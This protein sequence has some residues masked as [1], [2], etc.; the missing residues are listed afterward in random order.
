MTLSARRNCGWNEVAASEWSEETSEND[1]TTPLV[2]A[3]HRYFLPE[4]SFAPV[5]VGTEAIKV[6]VKVS[7]LRSFLYRAKLVVP[8][9]RDV[10][11]FAFPWSQRI[12]STNYTNC[13][14]K[15]VR[16]KS[17]GIMSTMTLLFLVC[18]SY[19][20]MASLCCLS[21]TNSGVSRVGVQQTQRDEENLA[22]KHL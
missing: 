21:R 7:I 18:I 12:Q 3:G 4:T 10:P 14:L 1:Q 2:R 11:A 13:K 6:V 9:P 8:R 15:W 5:S 20:M 17:C 16:L 19:C 22:L